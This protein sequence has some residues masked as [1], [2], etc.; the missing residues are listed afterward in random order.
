MCM[1]ISEV[2]LASLPVYFIATS[3]F[4]KHEDSWPYLYLSTPTFTASGTVLPFSLLFTADY[5]EGE[6]P[7]ML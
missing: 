6:Y 7:L 4:S 2:G 1:N 5:M 3:L